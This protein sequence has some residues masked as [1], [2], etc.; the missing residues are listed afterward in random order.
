M[1]SSSFAARESHCH[2]DHV[3]IIRTP[4]E[5]FGCMFIMRRSSLLLPG[6][7]PTPSKRPC[8]LPVMITFRGR[9]A[10]L[11]SSTFADSSCRQFS[12]GLSLRKQDYANQAKELN[13]KGLDRQEDGFSTQIDNAIG[14]AKELQARTPWHREG[15]DQPPVKRNRR[16][17]AMTKGTVLFQPFL[18]RKSTAYNC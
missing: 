1:P 17:G 10:I 5:V 4:F 2:E 11:Y 6:G 7:F 18:L 12:S 14:E 3:M 15:A 13:Q 9:P 16:A 8:Q